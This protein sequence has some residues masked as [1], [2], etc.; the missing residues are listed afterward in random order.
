MGLLDFMKNKEIDINHVAEHMEGLENAVLLDV[1]EPDEYA[2][3]H[4][5]GS[6]NLPL[7]VIANRLEELPDKE[8]PVFV[9]CQS[10]RRSGKAERILK[11]AGFTNVTNVGG[12]M[13]YGG[14]IEK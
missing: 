14:K 1:R 4:L 9:Y 7:S 10:G 11:E 6:T 12:I 3:G 8:A 13:S 5:P 2:Q